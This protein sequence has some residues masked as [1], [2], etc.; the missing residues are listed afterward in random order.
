MKQVNEAFAVLGNDGRRRAYDRE[1]SRREL[2]PKPVLNPSHIIFDNAKPGEKRTASFVVRN[3]GGPC[4]NIWVSDPASWVQLASYASLGDEEL[5]LRVDLT[6]RG[7]GWGRDHTEAITVDLDGVSTVLTLRLRTHAAPAPGPVAS[8][9]ASTSSSFNS[10]AA[11]GVIAAIASILIIGAA[12]TSGSS[13]TPRPAY[14]PAVY[15]QSSTNFQP[16]MPS[17]PGMNGFPDISS[18][19]TGIPSPGRVPGYSHPSILPQVSQGS[20]NGLPGSSFRNQSGG[21]GSLPGAPSHQPSAPSFQPSAPSSLSSAP[22]YR[23]N[24]P[25]YQPSFPSMPSWP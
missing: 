22:S 23:S 1:R 13:P 7:S 12:I 6:A 2:P 9:P 20:Q 25:S 8:A 17:Q 4:E 18:F 15:Q 24:A 10:G 11:F 16:A 14:H 3:D 19:G 5:P 21:F